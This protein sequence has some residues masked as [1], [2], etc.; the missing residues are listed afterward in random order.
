MK[1]GIM[2][3]PYKCENTKPQQE[4]EA[5]RCLPW[6]NSAIVNRKIDHAV[7]SKSFPASY[8]FRKGVSPQF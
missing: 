6:C 1:N 5:L 3:T 2:S 7:F 4:C 8:N